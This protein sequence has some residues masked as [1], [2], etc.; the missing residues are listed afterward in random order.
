MASSSG[1]LIMHVYHLPCLKSFH[2]ISELHNKPQSLVTENTEYL[3]N[4]A[5]H[6]LGRTGHPLM[7]LVTQLWSAAWSAEYCLSHLAWALPHV[8]GLSWI[9]SVNSSPLHGSL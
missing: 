1:S 5:T 6:E 7:I 9:E 4:R 8:C 3:F 2:C